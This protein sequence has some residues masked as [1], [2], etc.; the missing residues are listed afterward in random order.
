MTSLYT[1]IYTCIG[2]PLHE[3]KHP[4]ITICSQG[5]DQKNLNEAIKRQFEQFTLEI[6]NKNLTG[7][8]YR[9]K[10]SS[11]SANGIF[12]AS[13]MWKEYVK[14]YY[15]GSEITPN[16]LVNILIGSNPDKVLRSKILTNMNSVCTNA[17][18]CSTP[19]QIN[20]QNCGCE[21]KDFPVPGNYCYS[22]HLV[23]LVSSLL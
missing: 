16:S 14:T 8:N 17:L 11:T 7:L 2:L 23:I 6:K 1:D 20:Q 21:C 5:L 3:I 4:A 13:S 18:D 12:D 15:P 22:Y 19:I 10:K 9:I